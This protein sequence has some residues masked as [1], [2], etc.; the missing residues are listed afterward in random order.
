M[1]ALYQIRQARRE[2]QTERLE[3]RRLRAEARARGDMVALA[4]INNRRRT[5]SNVSNVSE[6]RE[7]HEQIQERRQ[8]AVSS[9]SYHDL[10]VARHDGTRIRANS[11]ESE[12]VGLL[13]DAASI[14]LSARSPTP[15]HQRGRSASSVLSY[16]DESGMPSPRLPVSG[17]TTPRLGSHHTRAGSSPDIISEADLA[18]GDLDPNGPPGYEDVSLDDMRSR[19]ATPIGLNEPP[20]NY[21]PGDGDRRGSDIELVDRVGDDGDLSTTADDNASRRDSARSSIQSLNG[22]T[23]LPSIRVDSLPEIVIEPTSAHPRR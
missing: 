5:S 18:D 17:A 3:R 22:A 21:Y 2:Q 11:T 4:E 14:A 16:D 19:S 10:G 9:V 8:R 23:R 6:L 13:S 15:S 20:P 1:E 7:A 12:R